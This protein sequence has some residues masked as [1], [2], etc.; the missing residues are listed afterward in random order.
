MLERQD[1]KL[2]E[3]GVV[4]GTFQYMAPEQLEGKEA[5]ARTDIFALG[6]VIYE[7]VTGKT[8][9]SGNNRTSL[10]TAILASEPLAMT[11]L[12]PLTPPALERVVKTCLAKD[13]DSRWQSVQDLKLQLD[14]D[15]GRRIEASK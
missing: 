9:F 15:R 3:K 12:Q 4:L 10:I 5:D 8:A 11:S 6:A 14:W 13:P 1:Q 2:T 7:M